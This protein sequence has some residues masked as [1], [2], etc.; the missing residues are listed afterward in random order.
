M[1]NPNTAQVTPIE[2]AKRK[3]EEVDGMTLE[4]GV[5]YAPI[6][7]LFGFSQADAKTI[8]ALKRKVPVRVYYIPG[9]DQVFD[10]PHVPQ[11]NLFHI[12]DV[13]EVAL[14][15]E[16]FLKGTGFPPY[17]YGLHGTGKTSFFDQLHARLGL[18]K[19]EI[20]LGEDS[21]V[22]DLGGQMLPTE[23]GGMKFHEGL[24][25]QSM[26]NGWT[27]MLDEYDLLPTRQQKMLNDV[28]ENKRFT[29]EV[30]GQKV[31]AHKNWR[32]CA[33]GNTNNSGTGNNLSVSGGGLDASVNERFFFVEKHYLPKDAEKR[34]LVNV[35]KPYIESHPEVRGMKDEKA[36]QERMQQ[37]TALICGKEDDKGAP[38]ACLIDQMLLVCERI[39]KAHINSKKSIDANGVCLESVMS[40]RALKEWC[41]KTLELMSF[42]VSASPKLHE[43]IFKTTLRLTFINGI[44]EEEQS[45]VEQIFD[46][47]I[48]S[49]K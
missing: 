10:H 23:A 13:M 22:I 3:T 45:I 7:K 2:Q 14:C 28:L 43:D 19:V 42:Y 20:I 36:K 38:M 31:I 24:L 32:V 37:L 46:D 12:F 26:R 27:L 41:K 44:A 18:P 40:T 4:Y 47:S 39:R 11:L 9:T 35:A 48:G 17:F 8:P 25:V 15:I 34:I 6:W 1:T 49:Q 33:C 30:T 5:S 29:I 21:E 16:Y